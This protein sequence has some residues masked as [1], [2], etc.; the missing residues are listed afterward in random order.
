VNCE[1]RDAREDEAEALSDI[2]VQSKGYWGYSQE[3]LE[4]W[5]PAMKVSPNYIRTNAVRSIFL[6]GQLV[7]FYAVIR[8][9][10]DYLDHL[11]LV[12]EAIGKGVGRL[13]FDDA[14][15]L[16][17]ELGIEALLIISDADAVGFYLKLG[18][19]KIGELFS[20]H[21]NRM[22]PKLR[23]QIGKELN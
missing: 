2:R 18:A 10:E 17:S 23:F 8:E 19:Q 21:Q 20:P 11:W 22:L 3:T 4:A 12:P 14:V 5:R 9:S 13:A 7:G 1:I 16:A 15:R 6:D